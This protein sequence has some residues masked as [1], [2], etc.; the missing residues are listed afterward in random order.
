M[1]DL[2]VSEV[3]DGITGCGVRCGIIGE[4]GC[5]SPLS[6]AE[7]RSLAAAVKAQERTGIFAPLLT[8]NSKTYIWCS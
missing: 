2:L 8:K 6:A 4:V 5:S 7:Q 3:M 1:T